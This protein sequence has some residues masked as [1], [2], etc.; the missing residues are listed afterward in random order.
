MNYDEKLVQ[1][2]KDVLFINF[3]WVNFQSKTL[4]R[5]DLNI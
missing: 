3:I 4:W 1:D 2:V 5:Y